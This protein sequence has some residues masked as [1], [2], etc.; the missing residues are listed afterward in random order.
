MSCL[1][2]S[3]LR[4]VPY[5]SPSWPALELPAIGLPLGSLTLNFGKPATSVR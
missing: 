5:W 3:G 1:R 4:L 2:W